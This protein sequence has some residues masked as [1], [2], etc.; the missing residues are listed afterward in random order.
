LAIA[1]ANSYISGYPDGTFKPNQPISRQEIAAVL[2]NILSLK[3]ISSDSLG[4]FADQNEIP[5]WSISAIEAISENGYMGGYPDG[6]F[7]PTKAL[8]RAEA[9]SVLDR[10]VGLLYNRSGT[11]GPLLT[12]TTI[13]GNVTITTGD[14]TLKNMVITGSLYLTEGV[15]T[16]ELTFDNVQVQGTA[17][18]SGGTKINLTPKTKLNTLLVDAPVAITGEGTIDTAYINTSDVTIETKPTKLKV[19]DDVTDFKSTPSKTTSSGSKK[20][21]KKT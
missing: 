5:F 17:K 21:S 8:T 20:K 2:T 9:I 10:A 11:F 4:K 15:E 14:V 12:T 1:K 19:A 18:I 6:T 16:G 3:G 13:E 7:Q